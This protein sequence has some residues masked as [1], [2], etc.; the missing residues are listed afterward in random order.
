MQRGPLFSCHHCCG[1]PELASQWTGG[2][3]GK[4]NHRASKLEGLNHPQQS[5]ASL[6]W[7]SQL[8]PVD[9]SWKNQSSKEKR[10]TNP[11]SMHELLTPLFVSDNL[12]PRNLPYVCCCCFLSRRKFIFRAMNCPNF[13]C[14][15]LVMKNKGIPFS[16][17]PLWYKLSSRNYLNRRRFLGSKQMCRRNTQRSI[18]RHGRRGIPPLIDLP[19]A[20]HSAS[21]KVLPHG[22]F[23]YTRL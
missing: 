6:P 19:E 4:C 8:T 1:S 2:N 21:I 10:S 13:L 18:I 15:N 3:E 5:M 11:K 12:A 14:N 20:R 16:S 7:L 17:L 9:L 23:N 22:C